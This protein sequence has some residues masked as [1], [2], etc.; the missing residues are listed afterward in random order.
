MRHNYAEQLRRLFSEGVSTLYGIECTPR[1]VVIGGEHGDVSICVARSGNNTCI[2]AD[3]LLQN[4]SVFEMYGQQTLDAVTVCGHYI[5][6]RLCDCYLGC[7]S[8]RIL[9]ELSEPSV[10]DSDKCGVA[11]ARA[12]MLGRKNADFYTRIREPLWRR[13]FLCSLC[14]GESRKKLM[15]AVNAYLA[16]EENITMYD[17]MG[18]PAGAIAK[19]ISCA[20]KEI[21]YEN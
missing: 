11:I 5:N 7:L 3:T 9:R 20:R 12:W 17:D 18:M 13:A 21:E 8:R 15:I 14:A 19:L 1:D 10:I 2:C 16:A 6:I 4:Q